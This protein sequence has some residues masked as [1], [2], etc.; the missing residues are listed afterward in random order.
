MEAGSFFQPSLPV[1]ALFN[2]LLAK[3]TGGQFILRIED[4]DQ[5]RLVKDAQQRLCEDLKWAGLTWDEGPE[6][7]GQHEPYNQSART[8]L[9][10]QHADELLKSGAA[11]RCFCDT[12]QAQA[13]QVDMSQIGVSAGGCQSD[14]QGIP[15]DESKSRAE[16]ENFAIRFG[17]PTTNPVWNDLVYGKVSPDASKK[18]LPQR[19]SIA[20]VILLKRDGTPTYH[21]ANVID[22]HTMEI[23]HVIRGTEWMP[24]T[25]LH[26]ALYEAFGWTPPEFAH[27]GLLTDEQ[28]NKLSKRN[29]DTDIGTL[30][31]K[32][33]ILSESLVNFLALLG[34]RNPQRNDAMNLEE[35]T[36]TF[37]LKFTRGNTIV[38]LDKLWFLQKYHAKRRIDDAANQEAPTPGFV[39]L[40][41]I[42]RKGVQARFAYKDTEDIIGSQNLQTYVRSILLIDRGSFENLTSYI[43]RNTY[44][45][46]RTVASAQQATSSTTDVTTDV[47]NELLIEAVAEFASNPE[48]QKVLRN[49]PDRSGENIKELWQSISVKSKG[50]NDMINQICHERARPLVTEG[51]VAKSPQYKAWVKAMHGALRQRLTYGASS[52]STG[53]VMAVLGYH[54]CKHRLI[55]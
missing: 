19:G 54:E 33:G 12:T 32:H 52:P 55:V 11:Y 25:A 40:A 15:G 51:E 48:L 4:T 17:K 6:V 24:S 8:H 37:D 20:D 22:D 46:S 14:C 31:D 50:C 45:F 35:L 38:T 23:T 49:T 2:Y 44:F 30:R 27:V 7:G 9:Y 53:L 47:D 21:L 39:E 5:K 1:L 41:D 42:V 3:K 26:V 29:F 18:N 34:W 13:A 16:K 10:Q 36:K 43:D 28:Q